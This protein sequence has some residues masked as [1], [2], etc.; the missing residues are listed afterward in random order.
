MPSKTKRKNKTPRQ[1]D[2]HNTLLY[3][4]HAADN[5]N[6]YVGVTNNF[7]RR[8]REHNGIVKGRGA[9]Y[10]RRKKVNP[11]KPNWSP[12][13]KVTGLPSRRQALQFEKLF[14]R[15]F[16]GRRLVKLPRKPRNPFGSDTAARRAWYLYWALQKERFSKQETVATKRLR[17]V[18]E[19]SRADFY[20][21]AKRLS[22]WGPASVRHVLVHNG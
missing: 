19:W 22:D 11:R 2:Q 16:R 10:T 1:E 9:R 17:L 13:F 6:S 15:G 4:I 5:G 8:L 18:I 21:T 12:I 14:H 3:A 7:E 20:A